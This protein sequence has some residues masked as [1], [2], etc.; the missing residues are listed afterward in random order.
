MTIWPLITTGFS[1]D[2]P[3]PSMADWP[4][5]KIGVNPSTTPS[6]LIVK[7]PSEI[8]SEDNLPVL[9]FSTSLSVEFEISKMVRASTFCITGTISPSFNAT[10]IPTFTFSC[11]VRR[12]FWKV[13]FIFGTLFIANEDALINI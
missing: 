3:I 1:T 5:F 11:F 4:A 12:L 6:A 7:V 13:E 8:S 10:A 2:L 9:A